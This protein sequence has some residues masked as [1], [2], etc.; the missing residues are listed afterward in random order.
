MSEKPEDGKV[1]DI[2]EPGE[3]AS[4]V[5]SPAIRTNPAQIPDLRLAAF[6]EK[7]PSNRWGKTK[8]HIQ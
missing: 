6:M 5:R 2:Q 4:Q 7:F 3:V 1:E 8:A